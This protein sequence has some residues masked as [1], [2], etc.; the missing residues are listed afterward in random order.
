MVGGSS[1]WVGRLVMDVANVELPVGTLVSTSIPLEEV[2]WA[3]EDDD[4]VDARA[5]VVVVCGCD[6]ARVVEDEIPTVVTTALGQRA[7]MP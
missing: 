6:C 7:G 3:A 5:W 1:A 4:V 2:D